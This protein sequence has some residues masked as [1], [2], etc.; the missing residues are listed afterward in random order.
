MKKRKSRF[1]DSVPTPLPAPISNVAEQ[2]SY[3]A[4][5]IRASQA[6]KVGLT[7]SNPGSGAGFG[8]GGG[9]GGGGG[10]PQ[11]NRDKFKA[12]MAAKQ[13]RVKNEATENF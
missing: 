9:Y 5:Q 12:L 4:A 11:S 8:G 7:F 1:S 10:R 3:L 13:V 2:A 6:N